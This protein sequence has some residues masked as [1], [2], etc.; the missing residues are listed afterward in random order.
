MTKYRHYV[1]GFFVHQDDAE[2][3]LSTLVELELPRERVS[4]FT[5][6]STSPSPAP[7]V[8]SDSVLKNVLVDGAIGTAVGT[9]LGA[10]RSV[11]LAATQTGKP[12][13][14]ICSA[15]PSRMAMS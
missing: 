5:A 2:S 12:G 14:P 6:D 11:A 3:T 15:T 9:G 8:T 10:L 1:S 13:F 7:E 4:I